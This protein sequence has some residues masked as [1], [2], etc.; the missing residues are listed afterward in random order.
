MSFSP[1]DRLDLLLTLATVEVGNENAEILRS[2][3]GEDVTFSSRYYRRRRRIINLQK[4]RRR[5]AIVKRV[6]SRA[7]IVLLAVMSAALITVMS[8]E[9]LR[10]AVLDFFFDWNDDEGSVIVTYDPL[11]E[12][13]DTDSNADVNEPNYYRPTYV[14]AGFKITYNTNDE[15]G[16]FVMDCH[17]D[18]DWLTYVEYPNG[19]AVIPESSETITQVDINGIVGLLYHSQIKDS[20]V[21][22]Y[23]GYE[24][25]AMSN[26][27]EEE[28]L[29]FARSVDLGNP[30]Y[31]PPT[32]I[33]QYRKPSLSPADSVEEEVIRALGAYILEYFHVEDD[34]S[35]LFY[36]Q[37]PK[38]GNFG[39]LNSEG[40]TVES[41]T[42]DGFDAFLM[43]NEE[44]HSA[45]LFWC[46]RDYSYLFSTQSARVSVGDL[47][48][49][50]ESI[51]DV[52]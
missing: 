17:K 48:K 10:N 39:T 52:E 32:K 12:I 47:M 13:K 24:F 45:F 27:G 35:M 3:D 46:D 44:K 33:E 43:R 4:T 11:E 42:V 1:F 40:Y 20:V 41:T 22:S 50:A 28:L 19:D 51:V 25:V 6:A 49:I 36:R 26:M 37:T 29:K 38:D 7:A 23:E 2:T 18:D 16:S 21:W 15:K 30:I 5:T 34:E 8:V 31:L 9:A 14:P